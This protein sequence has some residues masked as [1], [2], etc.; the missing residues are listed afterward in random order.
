M[1]LTFSCTA[2]ERPLHSG[3]LKMGDT[4]ADGVRFEVNNLYAVW[5]SMPIIPIMGE[6]HYSRYSAEE[7]ETELI[8]M[9]S[10]GISVIASYLMWIHHE[11][12]E[13]VF[14]FSGNRNVREFVKLCDK[15]GLQVFLRPGPWV[16]G[17]MRNG[18]FPDWL[19][20]KPFPARENNEGYLFYVRRLYGEYFRQLKGLFYCDG[21]PIIGM[22][23]ENELPFNPQHL[24][25]LKTIAQEA[26]F[27]VPLYTVTGWGP[28]C[29]GKFPEREV[30]PVF[31]GYPEA[32][33]EQNTFPLAPSPHYGFAPGRNDGTIGNDQMKSNQ[34]SEDETVLRDYPYFTCE[35]GPGVQVT[36]HRRPVIAPM[37]VYTSALTKLAKGNNLPGYYVFHGGYNP[38]D[39]EKTYQESRETQYPNDL[40]VV[41]YDFQAPIG[42]FGFVKS[43]YS[44]YRL[45]HSFIR[46]NEHSLAV[47][48]PVSPDVTPD[49]L[50]DPHT[51]RFL[52]RSFTS[53]IDGSTYGYLFFTTYM[54]TYTLQAISNVQIQL[55]LPR[56]QI[57]IS[58]LS[59]PAN[60]AGFF[61]FR[62]SFGDRVFDYLT[63]Q[64]V[65]RVHTP[66]EE[67]YFFAAI[68]G[69]P[70]RIAAQDG[71]SLTCTGTPKR[72]PGCTYTEYADIAPSC[73]RALSFTD[74]LGYRY[75]IVVLPFQDALNLTHV[76][77]EKGDYAILSEEPVFFTRTQ[78]WIQQ[79]NPNPSSAISVW[80]DP[81]FLTLPRRAVR[82]GIF[83]Q[84][85]LPVSAE[86]PEVSILPRKIP[87]ITQENSLT[88]FLFTPSVEGC[89]EFELTAPKDLLEKYEDIR[90][91]LAVEGDVLQI[92]DG[93]R[94]VYD[95]FNMGTEIELGLGRFYDILKEGR[96]LIFKV[97]PLK[98]SAN[99]Y[100]ERGISRE[101]VSVSLVKAVP[102]RRIPLR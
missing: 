28:G 70:V 56:E 58:N 83:T 65:T 53:S 52:A 69:V 79:Q 7:W 85:R 57:L 23:L 60:R 100:L 2:N 64:P 10:C 24:A 14:N 63:A 27:R 88:R 41:S 74:E 72:E 40:P 19:L 95:F 84:Y 78:A 87:T 71:E 93:Q 80:P 11:E 45:L 55:Q 50:T 34:P 26:G 82:D 59:I 62:F 15:L 37:D 29:V 47:C 51:P 94:L 42:E 97:S 22:Q 18:G 31:G 73:Q 66:E 17:E 49:S 46:E 81:R 12:E 21:G 90:L 4:S 30:L 89:G 36:Y 48:Q 44:Y 77:G 20:H 91:L 25:M 8:K 99:I 68:D 33:W 13:G 54:R 67:I 96:P 86:K 9:K 92:Y 35:L 101:C 38:V 39:G 1:K 43:S 98:E 75:S 76:T 32:P 6:F 5:D 16:H 102:V 3:H 61:P